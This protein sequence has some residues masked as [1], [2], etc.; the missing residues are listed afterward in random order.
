MNPR[1]NFLLI[2]LA[3]PAFSS[4]AVFGTAV[5][6][7]A[8]S[9]TATSG[10]K[11]VSEAIP[12]SPDLMLSIS[13]KIYPKDQFP[14]E[15]KALLHDVNCT[16]EPY[17]KV[18]IESKKE[19]ELIH[20]RVVFSDPD[21]PQVT[22]E[23]WAKDGNVKRATIDNRALHKFFEIE[24]VGDKVR[25]KST[26]EKD[27]S[28]KTSESSADANLV[29]PS[30]VMSYILPRFSELEQGKPIKIRVAVLDRQDAFS[31]EIKKLRVEKSAAG[32]DVVVLKMSPTSLFV[33]AL[34]D[35]LYFYIK[36]KT[37]EMFGFEGRSAL[38]HKEGDRYK[39]MNVETRYEYS[40]NR[41]PPPAWPAGESAN[42]TD[43]LGKENSMKC[44][45]PGVKDVDH[46]N[47]TSL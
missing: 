46:E 28:V 36:P 41:F 11:T 3:I 7:T 22:E 26:D 42:C 47:K 16:A 6:G 45:V 32:E 43:A 39:E 44:S 8:A 10:K 19:G 37:G 29:V 25:Y 24:I 18:S 15:C 5:S 40:V 23:S 21:G 2:L 34:V 27:K 20:S 33:K 12:A 38:R 31:F 4:A 17:G 35:P 14:A 1:V 30:T 9:G 13:G